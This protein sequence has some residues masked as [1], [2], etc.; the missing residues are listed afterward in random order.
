M[1]QCFR[2][3]LPVLD[4]RESGRGEGAARRRLSNL[5]RCTASERLGFLGWDVEAPLF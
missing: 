1:A 2:E 4:G 3:R 5:K